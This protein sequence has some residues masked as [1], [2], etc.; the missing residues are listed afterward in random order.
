[1]FERHLTVNGLDE[2]GIALIQAHVAKQT[3][4]QYDHRIF[5]RTLFAFNSQ[6]ESL[7]LLKNKTAKIASFLGPE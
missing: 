3:G 5:K 7:R 4:R 2:V 6:R 1:V